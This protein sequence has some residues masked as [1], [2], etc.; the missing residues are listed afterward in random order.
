MGDVSVGVGLTMT[1]AGLVIVS[2]VT[3]M[4]LKSVG[5][6]AGF[7]LTAI[8]F[9]PNIIVPS[10]NPEKSKEEEFDIPPYSWQFIA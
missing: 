5:S 4:P 1:F 7:V 9:V 10:Q 3:G 2:F 8:V 6:I